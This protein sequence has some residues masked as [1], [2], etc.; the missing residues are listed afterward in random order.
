MSTPN[1]STPTD[2]SSTLDSRVGSDGEF[3]GLRSRREL[4]QEC[5]NLANQVSNE[6][7][8]FADGTA[9]RGLIN[10]AA[11]HG[12]RQAHQYFVRIKKLCAERDEL[13]RFVRDAAETCGDCGGTG[14]W[15]MMLDETDFGQPPGSNRRDCPTCATARKILSRYAPNGEDE[16]RGANN[17]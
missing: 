6:G 3:G 15:H 11:A 13:L 9:F 16:P 12:E 14:V 2:T 4:A 10:E 1:D 7:C 17:T 8:S 5:A